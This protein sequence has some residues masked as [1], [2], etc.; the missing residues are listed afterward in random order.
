M[1]SRIIPLILLLNLTVTSFA[2]DFTS[3]TVPIGQNTAEKASSISINDFEKFIILEKQKTELTSHLKKMY[4]AY[5]I[6]LKSAYP[7]PLIVTNKSFSNG[8]LGITAYK[9]LY[10]SPMKSLPWAFIPFVG[11]I[12]ALTLNAMYTTTDVKM[13]K[14]SKV[15]QGKL[16]ST[17]LS[18]ESPITFD[19]LVPSGQV[20]IMAIEFND[21]STSQTFTYRSL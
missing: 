4:D 17:Q 6:T 16:S 14:E 18:K 8:V 10:I 5:K 12:P 19:L 1:K 11:I 7:N 15:Y 9:T 21:N 2:E 20:P 13:L 3:Q